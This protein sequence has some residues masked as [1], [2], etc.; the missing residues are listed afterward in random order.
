M[1]RT[2]TKGIV[3][4][5]ILFFCCALVAGSAYAQDQG[6]QRGPGK[7]PFRYAMK[8]IGDLELTAEQQAAL[9]TIKQETRGKIAPLTEEL[10][11]LGV[12]E[13]VFAEELNVA[14]AEALLAQAGELKAQIAA[15]KADAL[16]AVSRVLT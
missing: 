12:L 6:R 5:L 11:A 8:L 3:Y 1:V 2:K 7:K 4:A 10:K 9:E 16:L 14:V 15:V 13:T